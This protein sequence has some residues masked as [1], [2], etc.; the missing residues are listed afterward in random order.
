MIEVEMDLSRTDARHA[1]TTWS[2]DPGQRGFT[3]LEVSVAVA[4]VSLIFGGVVAVLDR[5]VDLFQEEVKLCDLHQDA[6]SLPRRINEEL[7]QADP[8]TISPLVL[9]MS[10]A[11]DF[12]PVVGSID[13][14]PQLGPSRT[15]GLVQTTAQSTRLGVEVGSVV[16]VDGTGSI[17]ILGSGV[18][19]LSFT[20]TASS[21]I[22]C[23]LAMERSTLGQSTQQCSH[24]WDCAFRN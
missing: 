19:S 13:G 18:T 12:Q 23:T 21:G 15:L 22:H 4:L 11:V 20:A 10:T 9:D 6:M 7:R 2:R 8:A 5:S 24:D 14:V 3:L 1:S 17:T 16:L